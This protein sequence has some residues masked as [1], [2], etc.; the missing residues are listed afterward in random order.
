MS[1]MAERTKRQRRSARVTLAIL[2]SALA[3]ALTA[4]DDPLPEQQMFT[5]RQECSLVRGDEDCRSAE[6]RAH[7]EH[8][9]TAPRYG[10]LNECLDIAEGCDEIPPPPETAS[11]SPPPGESGGS[12]GHTTYVPHMNGF[13]FLHGTPQPVYA[14][15]PPT[16]VERSEAAGRHFYSG[17]TYIGSP[18]GNTLRG[19]T[20]GVVLRASPGVLAPASVSGHVPATAGVGSVA[21]G[22]FGAMASAHAG[23]GA[24]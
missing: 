15:P 8:L 19:G 4:C 7:E 21:R 2:G 13:V 1:E 12:Q 23:G 24:A 22:G 16:G 10:S 14:G 17:S 20:G 18:A 3:P 11:A 9:L 5:T 6:E